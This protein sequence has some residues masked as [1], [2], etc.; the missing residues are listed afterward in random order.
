MIDVPE[1]KMEQMEQKK[2][3]KDTI[4]NFPEIKKDLHMFL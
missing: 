3:F 1:E 2:I 4:K